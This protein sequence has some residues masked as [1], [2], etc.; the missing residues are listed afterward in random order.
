M[1]IS[2]RAL[3]EVMTTYG[4][5]KDNRSKYYVW[6]VLVS[7]LL[8]YGAYTLWFSKIKVGEQWEFV[9][10]LLLSLCSFSVI[11]TLIIT[12]VDVLY[13]KLN[14]INGVYDVKIESSYKGKTVIDAKLEIKVGL[15]KAKIELRT[16]TSKSSSKT[17]FI[18][19]QDKDNYQIVYTYHNAG[20]CYNGNKLAKHEGTSVLT[21][22]KKELKEGFYYNGAERRTYGTF[23]IKGKQSK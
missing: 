10:Q 15:R 5:T 23:I 13:T 9:V 3:G 8:E 18:D 6:I 20:N 14:K 4:L 11:A 1:H 19:N 21:F 22:N 12:I 7:L 16:A 17:V 2:C